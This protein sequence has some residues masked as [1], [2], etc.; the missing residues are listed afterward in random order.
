MPHRES[1][2]HTFQCRYAAAEREAPKVPLPLPHERSRR[3]PSQQ[4][5]PLPRTSTSY[6]LV[7][8]FA[9]Q[10]PAPWNTPSPHPRPRKAFRK[11]IPLPQSNSVPRP[12]DI[13]PPPLF[14]K[15]DTAHRVFPRSS[16]LL[17]IPDARRPS[18]RSASSAYQ[19]AYSR[20]G[21]IYQ[22]AARKYI[23]HTAQAPLAYLSA[24]LHSQENNS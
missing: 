9:G 15:D 6:T 7:T 12:R 18:P 22:T 23:P 1:P 5:F 13:S 21:V 24:M 2:H 4:L 10:G 19:G 8:R 11:D 20:D 17:R 3:L 14:L 16:A